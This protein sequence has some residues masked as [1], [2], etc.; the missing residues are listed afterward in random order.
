MWFGQDL[1]NGAGLSDIED[2]EESEQDD[3]GEDDD[4]SETEDGAD[5]GGPDFGSDVSAH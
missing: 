1:F 4:D 5:V 3:D 2:E